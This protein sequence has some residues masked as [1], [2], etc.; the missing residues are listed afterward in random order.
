MKIHTRFLSLIVLLFSAVTNCAAQVVFPVTISSN[1]H[2]LVDQNNKPFPILGRT[3]WFIISQPDS[4]YKKFLDNTISHGHNAIEMSVITHWAMGNHAPFNAHGDA[5]FL[6]RL[7]GSD[8]DGKLTYTDIKTEGP[9]L[10][11]PNENYWKHIDELLSDCESKGILVFMFPGYAGY[12]S[13]TEEQGWM[14]ELVANGTERTEQYGAWIATR[15]KDRKNI[16]WMLLGDKGKFNEEQAKAETALIKGL[17]S[18]QGQQSVQYSAESYSGQNS[19]DNADFGNEMTLNA[20]Y[21]WE[22][23]VPVPYIARKAYAHDPVLPSFLLEEPYDEEGPDGNNYNPNATQPVRRFQWWGWLST[24]GGY[25]SGNGYV[26]QFVDPVWQQHLNTQAALDMSRLNS[27]IRS[28]NWW[29]LVP[30][31]LNGMKKLIADASNIDS[32]AAYV[33]AAATKDGSLLVAYIP[34]AHKG[35]ITV[36]MNALNSKIYGYWFDPTNGMYSPITGSPFS[37]MGVQSFTPPGK[38]STGDAD[39]VLM[40]SVKKK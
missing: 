37:N 12:S 7:N 19:A 36:N 2:Y 32:S 20:S 3:A 6:K 26:W 10:L 18:V 28:I 30:S 29:Q 13:E 21:T 15:Y 1:K 4:G 9:N 23:K 33:S 8:W 40:L 5:P 39:W 31:G 25:I 11:T 38:N 24:I 27:F 22:L 14:K 17:K 34:P 35:N 16:V